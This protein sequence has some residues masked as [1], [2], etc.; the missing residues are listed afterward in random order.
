MF[1]VLSKIVGFFA[2]PSNALVVLGLAGA[3]LTVSRFARAGRWMMILSLSVLAIAGLSP[4]GHVLIFPL[5]QRFPPWVAGADSVTGIVV[6]GGAI[7]EVI[8]LRR[9]PTALNDAAERMTGAVALARQFPDARLVFSGGSGALTGSGAREADAAASLFREL[10]IA[11]AR[12]ESE[13]GARNTAENA[14]FV[15]DMVKPKPGERWLLVTS[16]FHMPRSIGVF[17]AAGFT[18][19]P[20]PVDWR[21]AGPES[22]RTTFRVLSNGLHVTD[23]AVREWV[24]LLMYRLAGYTNELFPG[25]TARGCDTATASDACRR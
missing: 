23:L 1:F 15:N 8:S 22:V 10:G 14:R 20:Y 4:L 24:G 21:A 2:Q 11:P 7:D 9:G 25:P 16:A 3:L 5:E 13:D 12:L 17:R 19:E 18:V 6:L